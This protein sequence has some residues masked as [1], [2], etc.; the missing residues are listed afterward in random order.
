MRDLRSG[1]RRVSWF[2]RR[3]AFLCMRLKANDADMKSEE[4]IVVV[5]FGWVGQ[6]NALALVQ[7]GYS[8]FYYDVVTPRSY[9]ANDYARWYKKIKPLKTLLEQDSDSTWYIVSVGD[10]VSENGEQDLSLIRKALDSLR[11]ATGGVILRS[12]VLPRHLKSLNFDYYLPEFLHEKRAVEECSN[13]FYFIVGRGLARKAEPHFFAEWQRRA[14]KTFRGTP[15]Q[16][17]YIKY[18]S[19]VWNA[20]R[21]SFINEVGNLMVDATG[22]ADIRE[23]EGIIDFFF[24]KKNYLRYGRAFGGHCLPKDLRAF[25]AAHTSIGSVQLLRA[26]YA[27]NDTH[28]RREENLPEWFSA[29]DENRKAVMDIGF[30]TFLRLKINTYSWVQWVRRRLRFLMAGIEYGIPSRGLERVRDVWNR[31]A[32]E[33]ARYFVDTKHAKGRDITEFDVREFGRVDY[34]G[35]IEGDPL[36]NAIIAD[37]KQKTVLEIGCGIGRMTEFFAERFGHVVGIDISDAMVESAKKRLADKSAAV[38]QRSD[39]KSIDFPND[40]F[41]LIFSYQALRH[42]PTRILLADYLNEMRRTLKPGGIA[43]IHLRT[44]RGLHKWNWAYGVSVTPDGAAALAENAGF[45]VMKCEPENTKGLW[46]WLEKSMISKKN[47]RSLQ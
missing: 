36:L 34:R 45:R 1:S 16:A 28:R 35:Y 18:L 46:L 11:K 4:K 23:T 7:A 24:E 42:V 40:H 6:A 25:V 31:R 38:V 19:N 21:I 17:S 20:V 30:F 41:D 8:V 5:G 37:A 22:T 44:G 13:P 3:T 29:W 14:R 32:A 39:G 27:S 12:T 15:E 2:L 33:N 47:D 10:R 43:K 26:A 9:Y